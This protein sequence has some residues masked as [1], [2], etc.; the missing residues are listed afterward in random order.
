MLYRLLANFLGDCEIVRINVEHSLQQGYR[1][2]K[3]FLE[4]IMEEDEDQHK[5]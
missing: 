3:I 5:I 2:Y 1:V 4:K